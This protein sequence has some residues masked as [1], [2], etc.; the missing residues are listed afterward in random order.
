MSA[1]YRDGIFDGVVKSWYPNGRLRYVR[2]YTAGKRMGL[3]TV[4]YADGSLYRQGNLSR[5]DYKMYHP[6]GQLRIAHDSVS[7][8]GIHYYYRWNS[9]G[10][11]IESVPLLD[12]KQNGLHQYWSAQG[13]LRAKGTE[14]AGIRTGLWE[15]FDES[16]ERT[17]SHD[18]GKG[19]SWQEQ[20][21]AIID[22]T[23]PTYRHD[24]LAYPLENDNVMG[25]EVEVL[26]WPGI[27]DYFT[28]YVD[29]EIEEPKPLNMGDIQRLIGYPVKA[30]DGGIQGNVVVRMLIDSSGKPVDNRV[31]TQVSPVLSNQVE[32]YLMDLRLS[33]AT[34][35]GKAIPFWVN[36]PFNFKLL[37]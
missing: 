36:I 27:N 9:A 30:R 37:N 10:V 25:K 33:P 11:L 28:L 22:E 31:I 32:Y 29:A 8:D 6:N 16:G 23:V 1:N 2:E 3:E 5:G 17:E 14:T 21:S 34:I 24:G 20:Q 12:G 18:H 19:S 26:D 4:Y 7:A 15:Y 35:N 13:N